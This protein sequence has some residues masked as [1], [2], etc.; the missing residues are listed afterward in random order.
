MLLCLLC[1]VLTLIGW[2]LDYVPPHCAEA[3]GEAA[4]SSHTWRLADANG[5]DFSGTS[6]CHAVSSVRAQHSP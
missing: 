6:A 5:K 4:M 3:M 1:L 2:K